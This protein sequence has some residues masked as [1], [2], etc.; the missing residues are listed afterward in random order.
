MSAAPRQLWLDPVGGVAGD[1]MVAA[2]L[3]LGTDEARLRADLDAL[4]LEGARLQVER[5]RRGPFQ[6]RAFRVLPDPS[7]QRAAPGAHEH[8]HE[9]AH[10]HEHEHT[11]AHEHEHTHEHASAA[12]A[13]PGAWPASPWPDQPDR[14]WSDIRQLLL[15]AR[16]PEGARRRALAVFTALAQ[17]EAQVHGLPE[18]DVH[19]HEVGAVD[20]IIDVV[21]ASL[22]L[23]QLGVERITCGPPPLGQGFVH[24]AHG[25][26][27]LPAPATARLLIGWP[28]LA[29]LPDFEQTTPTGAALLRVLAEPG[30]LPSM[31]LLAVGHGAGGRDPTQVPNV[32]RA[33]LGEVGPIDSPDAVEVLAAQM[34]DLSGEH[35]PALLEALLDAGALDAWASPVLMKKG[36]SGL[37]VEALARPEQALALSR[38]LLRHGSTFG[39]RRHAARRQVLDRRHEPVQT[40]WGPIDMKIGSLDGAILQA[41]PEHAQ[42]RALARRFDLPEPQVHAAAL[43]AWW[44]RNEQEPG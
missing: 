38:V 7:G 21:A 24:G 39:V 40:P 28:V 37:L 12:P 15:R 36:R 35:L 17:A 9:H 13:R 1:M 44:S 33:F 25:R 22:L 30:P 11:H 5:V 23:D 26:I 6:A 14:R 8:T 18:E 42:V 3:D 34:D 43:A 31:R 19:F 41:A 32:L 4:G 10:E 20:S 29:G 27:P 2:L 16:L